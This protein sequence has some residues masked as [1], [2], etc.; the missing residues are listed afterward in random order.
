MSLAIS[1]ECAPVRLVPN[2]DST[3]KYEGTETIHPVAVGRELAGIST[4]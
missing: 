3:I 1:A 4:F 2:L